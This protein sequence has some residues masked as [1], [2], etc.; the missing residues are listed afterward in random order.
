ML[1]DFMCFLGLFGVILM[2]ISN[3]IMFRSNDGRKIQWCIQLLITFSSVILMSLVLIYHYSNMRLYAIENSLDNYRVGL[4][5]KRIVC[6]LLEMFICAIHPIPRPFPWDWINKDSNITIH[7][8]SS[9]TDPSYIAINVAL[10]LPSK[11][12]IVFC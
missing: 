7:S 4:T 10:G 9:N 2:L 12:R 1:S 11:S 8:N 5:V 3:E 6:I